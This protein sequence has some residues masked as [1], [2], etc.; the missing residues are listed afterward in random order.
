MLLGSCLC[1]QPVSCILCS[2]TI[3]PYSLPT[4]PQNGGGRTVIIPKVYSMFSPFLLWH[5]TSSTAKFTNPVLSW[6][7]GVMSKSVNPSICAL[8]TLS[9]TPTSRPLSCL[10]W[11]AYLNS[12]HNTV[13]HVAFDVG[14]VLNRRWTTCASSCMTSPGQTWV[15][16]PSW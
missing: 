11:H 2:V 9:L 1:Y 15:A 3:T 13:S 12:R 10:A 4:L 8:L 16:S 14:V 5:N 6:D 7:P